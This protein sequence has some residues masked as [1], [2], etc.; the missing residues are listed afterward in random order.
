M[1]VFRL[2]VYQVPL[3]GRGL[4]VIGSEAL[5]RYLNNSYYCLFGNI[6]PKGSVF[7]PATNQKTGYELKHTHSTGH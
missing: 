4:W 2:H 5:Q 1:T 6:K 7:E 3:R